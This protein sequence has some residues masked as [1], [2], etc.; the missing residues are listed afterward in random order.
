ML[1][2]SFKLYGRKDGRTDGRRVILYPPFRNYVATGDNNSHLRVW[3]VTRKKYLFLFQ[4]HAPFEMIHDIQ[5]IENVNKKDFQI[6]VFVREQ[7]KSIE[8]LDLRILVIHEA[9]FQ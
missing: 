9:Q 8:E 7:N 4:A 1:F 2:N 5:V 3:Q 6:Q